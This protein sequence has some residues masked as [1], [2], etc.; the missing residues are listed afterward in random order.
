VS[1]PT[2]A[3]Y[4]KRLGKVETELARQGT[5][6][7]D[8]DRR[9]GG[10][11]RAQDRIAGG[12]EELL[13]REASR[14]QPT[15]WRAIAVTAIALV[16]GIG[17]VASFAW[18]LMSVSPAVTDLARKLGDL[19]TATDKRLTRIDDPE[20]GRLPRAEKRLDDLERWAPVVKRAA[21]Y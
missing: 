18:W 7:E 13:R 17:M 5:R 14:P 16:G 8:I 19:A 20:I 6:L 3:N 15:N 21:G 12:V 2:D 10:M 4:D 1:V 11:E 9:I